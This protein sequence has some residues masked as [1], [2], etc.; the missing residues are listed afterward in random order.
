MSPRRFLLA[1]AGLA[2]AAI[3]VW[4]AAPAPLA[5]E[6]AKA[7]R[8]PI[9]VTVDEDGVTRARDRYVVAAPVAGRLLRLRW[10]EGDAVRADEKIADIAPLPLSAADREQLEAKLEGARAMGRQAEERVARAQADLEQARRERKRVEDLVAQKFV[11]AQALEQAVLAE[12]VKDNDA[13]A[14]RSQ[15]IA[16]AADVKAASGALASLRARAPL[17]AVRAPVAGRI[18]T[19]PEKSERVVPAGTPIATVG[20]PGDLE[21]VVDLLSSDA[22]RVRP[23]TRMLVA[24]WGGETLEATVRLVEP[25]AFRKISALGVEEQRVNVIA[26]FRQVPAG[27]GDAYRIDARVVIAERADALKVPAGA[28]FRHEGRWAVYRVEDGRARL[29]PVEAGLRGA[30]EVEV[31]GGLAEGDEVVLYPGNELAEGRRIRRTR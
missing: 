29:R 19:I 18:L 16:A 22:V 27:L 24:G 6:V 7:V 3:L 21:L 5:V 15:A 30:R 28:L 2:L 14:M 1:L 4:W 11:S 8:G 10:R 31:A 9:E 13:R 26:D 23:G 20:D 17:V 12:R 25:A